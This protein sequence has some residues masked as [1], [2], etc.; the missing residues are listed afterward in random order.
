MGAAA[1]VNPPKKDLSNLAPETPV[2]FVPMSAV[3][4]VAGE[5]AEAVERPLA[6]VQ[7]GYTQ[8]L[9]GDVLFAKITPCMENG[10]SAVV[11]EVVCGVGYGSTE[12]YVLRPKAVT[13]ALLYRFVRSQVFRDAAKQVMSGAVGQQRVPKAWMAQHPIPLPPPAE[14]RRLA[15]KLDSLLAEVAEARSLIDEAR[16]TLAERR[17]AILVAACSG[18]LTEDCRAKKGGTGS[19]LTGW[20]ATTLDGLTSLV[21]SGSRGWAEFYSETGPLFIRA[22][23]IN[24]DSLRLEDVAHFQAP[25]SAEGVR[26]R[27]ALG[28]LLI[29]IT[30]ANVTKAA[31]LDVDPGEAHVSQHVA[32]ARPRDPDLSPVL[33]FWIISPRHGRARLLEDAYGLGKPG[34]KLQHIRKLPVQLPSIEEQREI[35]RRVQ[36]LFALAAAAEQAVSEAAEQLE[37]V[38]QAILARTFRGELGTNDPAEPTALGLLRQVV[39]GRQPDSVRPTPHEDAPTAS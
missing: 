27:A 8:F 9:A 22:Q 32:L 28:D 29:T 26:P 17:A 2:S 10:N 20:T 23:N 15:D 14:Q 11:K 31:C 38:T 19:D 7:K 30:G 13:A 35:V 18:R 1:E 37:A 25:T 33:H 24:T 3:D 12:F 21:P 5:I 39:K 36:S 4:E 16:D 6:E 34:L